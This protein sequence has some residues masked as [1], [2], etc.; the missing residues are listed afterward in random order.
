MKITLVIL[1]YFILGIMQQLLN[2]IQLINELNVLLVLMAKNGVIGMLLLSKHASGPYGDMLPQSLVLP[3]H[4]YDT[5]K[6]FLL[7]GRIDR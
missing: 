5:K 2:L 3:V 7:V 1:I 4:L 6:N